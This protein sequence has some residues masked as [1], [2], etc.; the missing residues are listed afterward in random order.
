LLSGGVVFSDL[1]LA[2]GLL[3]RFKVRLL[4]FAVAIGDS[5][6]VVT[7]L[8]RLGGRAATSTSH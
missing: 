3:V 7:W 5:F 6:A 8:E 1:L 2:A 4:A